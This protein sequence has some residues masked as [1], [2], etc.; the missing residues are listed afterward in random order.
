MIRIRVLI[1]QSTN[2]KNVA[3]TAA[4]ASTIP[5]DTRV[6]LRVGQVTFSISWRTSRINFAGLTLA[7]GVFDSLTLNKNMGE[8]VGLYR[9]KKCF[10]G[11]LL[12]RWYRLPTLTQKMP[13][14]Q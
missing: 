8:E 14:R 12:A 11:Y 3:A 7:I 5:V 1:T 10:Q 2:T 13:A 9:K 6:S 4:S